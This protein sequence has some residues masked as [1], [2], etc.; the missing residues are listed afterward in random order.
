M[1]IND[2]RP[3]LLQIVIIVLATILPCLFCACF[4]GGMCW[5]FRSNQQRQQQQ[6]QQQQQPPQQGVA[7][8]QG[9]INAG[10]VSLYAYFKIRHPL[11]VSFTVLCLLSILGYGQPVQYVE[12]VAYVQPAVVQPYGGNAPMQQQQQQY[13]QPVYGQPV[14]GQPVN[15]QPVYSQ[16]AYN[17]PAY[18]QPVYGQPTNG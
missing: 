4:L 3:L 2:R 1:L 5:W 9:P 17:Q 10:T 18:G 11:Y 6:Q 8:M 16:P 7:G 15:G 12:Q 13:G 14:N